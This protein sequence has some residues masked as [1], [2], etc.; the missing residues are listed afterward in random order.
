MKLSD[1]QMIDALREAGHEEAATALEQKITAQAAVSGERT[2]VDGQAQLD[3]GAKGGEGREASSL[4][5]KATDRTPELAGSARIAAAYGAR[6][7]AKRV[8][9][10]EGD[11]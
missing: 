5:A 4:P 8:A 10:A 11:R 9:A 6:A 3:D 2:D 1:S 7:E